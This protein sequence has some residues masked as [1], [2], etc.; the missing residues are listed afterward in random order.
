MFFIL[1]YYLVFPSSRTSQENMFMVGNCW[2]FDH[3]TANESSLIFPLNSKTYSILMANV[4]EDYSFYLT[5]RKPEDLRI[6]SV[7]K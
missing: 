1:H 5:I 4:A 7:T 2:C 3:K 6:K